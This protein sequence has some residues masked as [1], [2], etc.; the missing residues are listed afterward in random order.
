MTERTSVPVRP[1]WPALE[2]AGLTVSFQTRRAAGTVRVVREVD[3][4]VAPGEVMALVG[5]SGCGKSLTALAALGLLP[6]GFQATGSIRLNGAELLGLDENAL[7]R[8]RGNRIAMVF[9][10]PMT[11]LNPVMSVGRQVA[12]VVERHR[13]LD[14]RAALAQVARLFD[15][16][17]LPDARARL[18]A[19]PFELS[20]G[21]RQRVMIAM[22]LACGPSVLI[23]DEPTTALDVTVQAQ[24]LDLMLGLV[25][26]A[27]MALLLITH[28][29]GVVAEMADRVAVMYAGRIVET[30]PVR[31]LFSSPAH[32]Y[33]AA[34]FESLPSAATPNRPLASIPGSVPNPAAVA[35]GCAFAPRCRHS[36][37]DCAVSPS[38]RDRN[39]GHA[40]ACHFPRGSG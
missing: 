13:G 14:R 5:E 33:T 36:R 19:Y 38:L 1:D 23:A 12:E 21:Q 17:R 32:P 15:R 24:I 2:I 4:A 26:E 27:G 10:E 7:S 6:D 35:G 40:V 16:V 20:G 8:L 31:S 30:A 37:D 9:Q 29:L 18:R 28:D 3:L 34:L 39:S 25:E 11:A 22:A